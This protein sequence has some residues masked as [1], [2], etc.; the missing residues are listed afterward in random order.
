MIN[1]WVGESTDGRITDLVTSEEFAGLVALL[2]NTV[3][4]KGEWTDPFDL[5]R[6]RP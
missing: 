2:V 3:Y 4:F 6:P 1:G 5:F